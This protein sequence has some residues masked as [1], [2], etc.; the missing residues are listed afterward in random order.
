M[1]SINRSGTAQEEEKEYTERIIYYAEKNLLQVPEG[2]TLRPYI[3]KKL[4]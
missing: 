2:Q 4:K 1:T 3:A